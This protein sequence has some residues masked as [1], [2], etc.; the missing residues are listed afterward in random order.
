MQKRYLMA[1]GPTPVAP[2][3]LLAMAEPIIHHRSPQ[4]SAILAEVEEGLKFIFQTKNEVLILVA[5]GTGAMEGAVTNFLSPGDKALVVRGGK[6]GE[7]W[8]EICT[9]YGVK[10]LTI[11][12][13]WGRS[14]QPEAIEKVL[15]TEKDIKAVYIQAHETSTG[16]KHPVEAIGKLVHRFPGTILVVDA[17]S[18]LGV[19]DIKTD[20]WHVDLLVSGSQKALMLPPGLAFASVSEKAWALNKTATLPRYYFDFAK[21]RKAL[22]KN[23]GAY[24]SAVSLIIGLQQVLRQIRALGLEALFAK[25]KRL[26]EATKAGIKALGLNFYAVEHPSEA[27]TAILAPEGINGQDVVKVMRE[28]YGVTIAGGQAQAKG[29]IFRISHM[30]YVNEFDV[31]V[32]LSALE[33]A[34]KDLGY[35]VELGAGVRAAEIVFS[36]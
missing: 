8:E 1:P 28:K 12:V 31:I 11:D 19:Y 25:N 13:E 18:A 9:A 21:E 27:L 22:A 23:T 20:D 16:V 7:R 29:K 5:S 6:F 3:T 17:I 36:G 26:S 15:N 14:I 24:T 34:L 4:F 35:P 33:L 2:D 32:A 30:G 10:A